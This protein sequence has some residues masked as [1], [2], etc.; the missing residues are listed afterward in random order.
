M[1]TVAF[2][3]EKLSQPQFYKDLTRKT[4]VFEGWSW[5]RFNNLELALGTNL[6]FH[7][8][9]AKGLK[10]KVRK[11]RELIR[12][13]L[14]VPG[15]KL[16]GE[17][18]STK[19]ISSSFFLW[20]ANHDCTNQ[21]KTITS[22]RSS[23][24]KLPWLHE[25]FCQHGELPWGK[26]KY[27]ILRTNRKSRQLIKHAKNSYSIVLLVFHKFLYRTYQNGLH[28]VSRSWGIAVP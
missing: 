13:F 26:G 11:F 12:T 16:E 20:V 2:L 23:Q 25:C 9:V 8:C 3:W 6:K 10:L 21:L 28:Q 1:V 7:T 5:F 24:Y 15:E 4:T 22:S 14:E 17:P 27:S 19:S 18:F